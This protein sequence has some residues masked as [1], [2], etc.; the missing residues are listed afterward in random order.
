ME[1]DSQKQVQEKIDKEY[2]VCL[3]EWNA[4]PA[5]KLIE[6]SEEI[7]AA[8][9]AYER[10]TQENCFPFMA[11]YLLLDTPNALAFVRDFWLAV[12]EDFDQRI[13]LTA[14][15]REWAKG[16]LG[17]D[18]REYGWEDGQDAAK[19]REAAY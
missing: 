2:A 10:L 5:E 12:K 3:Q 9:F 15:L 4:L 14:I 19:M 16:E 6:R 11:P 17:P 7:S 13:N 1:Q 8:K 18:G